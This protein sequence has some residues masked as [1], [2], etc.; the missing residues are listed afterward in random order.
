MGAAQV[1]QVAAR[2]LVHSAHPH[3]CGRSPARQNWLIE[4]CRRAARRRARPVR[5]RG[6]T[7]LPSLGVHTNNRDRFLP[8]PFK[9]PGVAAGVGAAR[10]AV[11]GRAGGF[12]GYPREA[13]G[14]LGERNRALAGAFGGGPGV[15]RP[16]V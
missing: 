7:Q 15:V 1:Q 8:P 13:C 3:L 16:P 4:G 5:R 12:E 14:G 11:T 6:R 2:G 10:A 9:P